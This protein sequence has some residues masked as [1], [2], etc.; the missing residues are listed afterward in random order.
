[1]KKLIIII[2][3]LLFPETFLFA[4]TIT[5]TS[6]INSGEGTLREAVTNAETN[7]TIIFANTTTTITLSSQIK[8]E[9]KNITLI[10]NGV[11]NTIITGSGSDR[12]FYISG[13]STVKFYHVTLKNGYHSTCGAA[14]YSDGSNNLTVDNCILTQNRAGNN[15]AAIENGG[16]GNLIVNDCLFSNNI[17]SQ[18]A[19]AIY[20][21]GTASIFNSTFENNKTTVINSMTTNIPSAGAIYNQVNRTLTLTNCIFKGNSGDNSGVIINRGNA[22]IINSLFV[23]NKSTNYAAHLGA[24]FNFKLFGGDNTGSLTILNSTIADNIGAGL[25]NDATSRLYI[26][27]SIID[28]NTTN[29][30]YTENTNITLDNNLIGTSNIE[31]NDKNNIIGEAPLFIGGGD[32]SLQ[33]NSPAIDKGNNDYFTANIA[34]DLVGNPRISNGTIDLGAC[35]FQSEPVS[36]VLTNISNEEIKIYAY[37]HMIVVEN[38]VGVIRIYDISGR[39][40][41]LGIGIKFPVSQSGIYIVKNN[42]IVKKV[43]VH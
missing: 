38:A 17:A 26:Y 3:T 19:G 7:D 37:N 9:G 18:A 25:Y 41:T 33:E 29:D 42:N 11:E 15:G 31:L 30:I 40:I 32:Y 8:I 43:M 13:N 36:I 21:G 1:M 4:K 39:C 2:M 6:E 35:E 14:I 34:T 12:L 20:N 27:N 22:T 24:I 28:G 10:G 5:V 16:G 23:E